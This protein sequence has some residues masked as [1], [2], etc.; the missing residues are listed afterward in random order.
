MVW[1]KKETPQSIEGN[2]EMNSAFLNKVKEIDNESLQT[3]LANLPETVV[4]QIETMQ[5]NFALAGGDIIPAD[6][7][8]LADLTDRVSEFATEE[9]TEKSLVQIVSSY[10]SSGEIPSQLTQAA[11]IEEQPG[12]QPGEQLDRA[13]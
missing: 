12:E 13:A 11:P 2:A 4:K 6:R 1:R 10:V 8:Q 5:G 3:V 9:I 7:Q